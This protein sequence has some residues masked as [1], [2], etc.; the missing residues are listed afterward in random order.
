M[1]PIP[2]NPDYFYQ[3][4][5]VVGGVNCGSKNVPGFYVDVSKYRS[6]IDSHIDSLQ[7]D[8]RSYNY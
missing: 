6:W 2:N 8:K 1:C 4:G 5:I 3:V 7:L